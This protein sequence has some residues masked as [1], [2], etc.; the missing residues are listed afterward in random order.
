MDAL[1]ALTNA[2]SNGWAVT[3]LSAANTAGAATK[4]GVAR[5]THYVTGYSV[6]VDV[7][8]NAAAIKQIT[9]KDGTTDI[10]TE[11]LAASAAVG[12]KISQNFPAPI[13]ITTG[14]ACSINCP[15]LDATAKSR[16]NLFG[17]TI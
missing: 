12:T 5:K 14:A 17:Y 8:A 1:T 13:K 16:L 10:C 11:V 4:A 15:A 9:L 2:F 6:A 3:A 7:A